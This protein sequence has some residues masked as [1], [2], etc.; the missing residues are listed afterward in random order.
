MLTAR[1][2]SFI[3]PEISARRGEKN[4]KRKAPI[5]SGQEKE[6]KGEQRT[7]HTILLNPPS[8]PDTKEKKKE[9]K[10]KR[11]NSL[12]GG[13]LRKGR[14]KRY[15]RVMRSVCFFSIRH[16]TQKKEKG[17][18]SLRLVEKKRACELSDYSF[19]FLQCYAVVGKGEGRGSFVTLSAL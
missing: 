14:E 3:A 12:P 11:R 2:K 16:K 19:E 10:K 4:E 15:R 1:D 9:K 17:A 6:K 5:S 8:K 7:Y 13:G 18:G